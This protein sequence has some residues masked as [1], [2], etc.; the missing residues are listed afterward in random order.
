MYKLDDYDYFLPEEL[1]AQTPVEPRD[2]SRL[3]VINKEEKLISEF[4]FRDIISFLKKGDLLVINSTR[5]IPARLIGKKEN[6]LI[7]EIFL[8]KRIDIKRWECLVKPGK[9]V[10]PGTEVIIGE[11]LKAVVEEIKD[12]G[13][14]I[15]SFSFEG[16]FEEILYKLGE[17]PLPP[18]INEKLSEK[19]RYQTVYAVRGESVAAPTA[20]LHFTKELL[21]SISE[22]GIE[23][24]EVFLDVGLGTFRPV[25]TNNILEHNMH[26][27]SYEIPEESAK[28]INLAKAEGRRVIAVGTTSVRTL[29]S[30]AGDNKLVNS[31][32]NLTN[33]FIFP[34]YKFKIVDALI[35][36]FHLPKST[37]IMLV[38]AFAGKELVFEA[39]KKAVED[40]YRFFSFGDAMFLY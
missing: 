27:E 13:N 34:G 38:S 3:M 2:S 12:D 32:K 22:K 16:V 5:V 36:N 28:K 17:M 23:I 20:G 9:R 39:Y 29:E 19:D 15:I 24:A 21:S 30:A 31:G 40:R 6:G 11:E 35:T 18:Y 8:L 7:V 37:L 25:K 14:R 1:I 33:I 10:R 4:I 26:S